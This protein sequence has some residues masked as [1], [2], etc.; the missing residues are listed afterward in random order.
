MTTKKAWLI[1]TGSLITAILLFFMIRWQT[2]PEFTWR[3]IKNDSG[4]GYEILMNEQIFIH[5]DYLPVISDN[6]LLTDSITADRLAS[7]VASKLSA[8]LSPALSEE[9]L[10]ILSSDTLQHG[11]R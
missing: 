5:Q 7:S 4:W 8:G 10:K 3:V 9:E 2:R 1:L 11:N 6:R